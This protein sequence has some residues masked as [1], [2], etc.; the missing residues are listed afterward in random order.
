MSGP[1]PIAP[2]VSVCIV[3]WNT[4]AQLMR[5][6]R[7]LLE[8]DCAE[9]L[10]IIVVDNASS[11]GS[12]E[13]VADAFGN[14]V[15]LVRNEQNRYYAAAS[16]QAFSLATGRYVLAL[17]PDA[18]V[19]RGAIAALLS[20]LEARP[21]AAAVAPRLLLPDGSTQQSCRRFPSPWWMICEATGLRR[22]LPRSRLFGGYFY[23]EWD[24]ATPREVDQP[25]AS[26][27]LVCRDDL[28]ELGGFDESFPMFWNDVDLCFRLVER[29]R[30]ILYVP[31]AVCD[32]DHGASTRQSW[33]EMVQL[34]MQGLLG[35]YGK[36]YSR[37]LCAPVYW[38]AVA[39]I[40][41]GGSVRVAMARLRAS[42]IPS[43]REG[44]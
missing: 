10:E 20:A 41:L 14:R 1:A 6:V 12:A 30:R 19:H 35:F 3:N 34:S 44:A 37:R 38:L 28:A 27:F 11:D 9:M 4:R 13:A 21:D 26:C 7:A 39:L 29:G 8:T 16:N 33:P 31:S 17:N 43:R 24:Y 15:R 5:C 18:Y 22:L 23:G 2:T 40:K 25:M 36:H 32:H 42:P